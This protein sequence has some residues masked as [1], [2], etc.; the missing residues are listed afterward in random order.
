MPGDQFCGTPRYIF[1][2]QSLQL[3]ATAGADLQAVAVMDTVSLQ[4]VSLTSFICEQHGNF[5]HQSYV[6]FTDEA[7]EVISRQSF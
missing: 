5:G 1:R 6:L 3:V 4:E 7:C 2:A